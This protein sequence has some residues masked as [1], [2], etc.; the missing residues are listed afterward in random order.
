MRKKKPAIAN[1][2]SAV[3]C[4]SECGDHFGIRGWTAQKR[5]QMYA[6]HRAAN[7]ESFGGPMKKYLE[8][9]E[10]MHGHVDWRDA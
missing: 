6:W 9:Y 1:D 7:K 2:Y 5:A 10:A 4:N 3:P 8:S